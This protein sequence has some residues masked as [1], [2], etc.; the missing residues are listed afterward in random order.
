MASTTL[1]TRFRPEPQRRPT[2]G[3]PAWLAHRRT[4]GVLLLSFVVLFVLLASTMDALWISRSSFSGAATFDALAGFKLFGRGLA[5]AF[6][7]WLLLDL[8]LGTWLWKDPGV[9]LLGLFYVYAALTS[10]YSAEPLLSLTRALSFLGVLFFAVVLVRH[11]AEAGRFGALWDGLYHVLG[12]YVTLVFAA[13]LVLDAAGMKAAEG[14]LASLYGPN[15]AASLAG[16]VFIWS[17]VRLWQGRATGVLLFLLGTS[18]AFMVLALSR[19]AMLTV[20]VTCAGY[21]VWRRKSVPSLAVVLALVGVVLV[22]VALSESGLGG[23]AEF[24]TRGHDLDRIQAMNGRIPIYL[25]LLFEQ[26]PQYPVFGVGFQMMSEAGTVVDVPAHIAVRRGSWLPGHAHNA[27]LQVLVGTGLVGL[28]L[29]AAA[30]GWVIRG[31]GRRVRFAAPR[32]FEAMVP[33]TFFILANSMVE[34][35]LT[36]TIDPNYLLASLV[37]ASV[38]ATRPLDPAGT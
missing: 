2:V 6:G 14:R 18:G 10:A 8:R 1:P 17:Y 37:A 12:A 21:A 19:G 34:T 23:L 24:F 31:L 35:T 13:S 22:P 38:A 9:G 7:C 32:A 30:W 3:F 20:L 25:Y 5:V 27:I 28:A 11:A 4:D 16:L 29:F 26:F 36:G 15:G 33:L